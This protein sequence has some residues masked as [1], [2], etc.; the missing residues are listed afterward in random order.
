MLESVLN[1]YGI[2]EKSLVVETF[3]SGLINNTWK[4]SENG[5]AFIVQKINTHVFK[6]PG[7]IEQNID[8]I[9]GF[10]R[11]HNPDY[12]FVSPLQAVNG[13]SMVYTNEEDFFRAFPF[14][15]GSYSKDIVET[16]Q[17]AFEA[18]VQFGR[19]TK[20]L[21]GIDV[22][23]LKITI[24]AFHDLDLRYNHF[25]TT[26]E[27]GNQERVAE[28]AALS[29]QL[30]SWAFIT[31]TYERIKKSP[32]FKLR[33]THHDTKISNVLFNNLDK[34]LCVIDLD[35]VMPGYFISDLGDMFRTYL[36]PCSE[37]EEDISKVLV[38]SEF[39]EAITAGYLSEMGEE[40]T[41]Q[42]KE[43]FI[44]AG[45][46]MIYMQ[47]LRFLSDY[48]NGDVYYQARYSK[49]NMVRAQNQIALLKVYQEKKEILTAILGKYL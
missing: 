26:L 15:S 17:Q 46:F 12:L 32:E 42:E 23:K 14:V 22:T 4:I 20:N 6:K 37:D 41:S 44:Y 38:R 43:H 25:L 9:A 33:V 45:E 18:A 30:K 28:C 2:V 8:L 34:G 48:I 36:S 7:D 5:N 49:H 16:P 11:L 40:L 10:L 29:E 21:T 47:A 19:F 35:T 24:P 39:F 13:K 1:Q 27:T 31:E 3:G